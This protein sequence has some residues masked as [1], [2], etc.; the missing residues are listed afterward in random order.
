MKV[1]SDDQLSYAFLSDFFLHLVLVYPT[2]WCMCRCAPIALSVSETS[3]TVNFENELHFYIP[4]CS[5][6]SLSI[7]QSVASE[8]SNNSVGR[9]R[10]FSFFLFSCSVP[11]KSSVR[12]FEL[13]K[14]PETEPILD[15]IDELSLQIASSCCY[16]FFWLEKT[17]VKVIL[18]THS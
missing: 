2:W 4:L 9:A 16:T 1:Q 10:E 7:S 14:S 13:R 11:L 6:F 18:D 15:L 3:I 8:T 12:F 17:N 5:A